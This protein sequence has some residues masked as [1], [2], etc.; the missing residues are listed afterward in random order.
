MP[1][2]L[3]AILLAFSVLPLAAHS[4]SSG[5]RCFA[6]RYPGA[7][8]SAKVG[9]VIRDRACAIVD[10][11]DIR[12]PQQSNTTIRFDRPI[13]WRMG[14]LQLA[15]TALPCIDVTSG[16]VRIEGD[17]VHSTIIVTPEA[18][19]TMPCVNADLT[20]FA[21]TSGLEITGISFVGGRAQETV[22]RRVIQIRNMR[23]VRIHDN[24]FSG[25][26]LPPE[27][28]DDLWVVAFLDG[29]TNFQAKNNSINFP[30]P[31]TFTDK[32][33]RIGIL[34]ASP[35]ADGDN[36]ATSGVKPLPPT[37]VGG[38]ISG[39]VIVNGTHGIALH[40]ARDIQ[41]VRNTLRSQGHRNIILY[42]TTDAV[43]I[44]DNTLFNAGSTNLLADYGNTNLRIVHNRLDTTRGGEGRNVE[45]Y[46]GN[47]NVTV[48]HNIMLNAHTNAVYVGYR[49]SDVQIVD[50]RINGN[51]PDGRSAIEIVAAQRQGY[52]AL[53][54]GGG[55][56]RITVGSNRITVPAGRYGIWLLGRDQG[57]VQEDSRVA[58][59]RI[60]SNIIAGGTAGI[61]LQ[62]RGFTGVWQN[63]SLT[64][65]T[66]SNPSAKPVE[67]DYPIGKA[68]SEGVPPNLF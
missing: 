28:M 14:P 59:I 26:D 62:K 56:E 5:K 13:T 46:L 3:T 30:L 39:N 23:D 64:G 63:I 2:R 17:R 36:G 6:S 61:L 54:G 10:T 4:A 22:A 47:S 25:F 8:L 58:D 49:A 68:G 15:T 37:V 29:T 20:H 38:E 32:S 11:S 24:R 9:A 41:V 43:Q 66:V 1:I 51:F 53:R 31:A 12:T 34:V 44:M 35:M 27:S 7:D 42:S 16:G 40:N 57:S 21:N 60:E 67:S 52:P 55:I 18:T 19:S 48:A 33:F 50:N 45:L 65:N